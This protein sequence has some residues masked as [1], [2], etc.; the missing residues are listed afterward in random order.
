MP[1]IYNE[2]F[3]R[4]DKEIESYQN[5]CSKKKKLLEAQAEFNQI[6]TE[7]P[8]GNDENNAIKTLENAVIKWKDDKDI[9]EWDLYKIFWILLSVIPAIITFGAIYWYKPGVDFWTE[10][11]TQNSFRK[12]VEIDLVE[13]SQLLEKE[14]GERISII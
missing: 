10:N 2:F 9:Q 11:K 8:K 14:N 6:V 12:M 4:L 5:D 3:N 7:I 1:K 13:A